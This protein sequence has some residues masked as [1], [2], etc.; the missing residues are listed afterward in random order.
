MRTSTRMILIVLVFLVFSA[1]MLQCSNEKYVQ[2]QLDKEISWIDS[3]MAEQVGDTL[4]DNNTTS[5]T[6]LN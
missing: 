4:K 5:D 6:T 1:I 3:V 2:N